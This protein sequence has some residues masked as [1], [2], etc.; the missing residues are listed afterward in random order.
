MMTK[1]SHNNLIKYHRVFLEESGS[2]SSREFTVCMIMDIM[3]DGDLSQMLKRRKRLGCPLNFKV[4]SFGFCIDIIMTLVAQ[5]VLIVM[6]DVSNGLM[7]LH[8]K[9]IIH[10][11]LKPEVETSLVGLLV[12]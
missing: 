7:Y 3:P 8:S 12:D 9:G 1:H 4:C 11:D 2:S 5:E 10:R 6:N